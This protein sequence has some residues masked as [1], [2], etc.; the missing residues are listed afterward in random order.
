MLEIKSLVC[1]YDS[2][3]LLRDI[4][5]NL[6]DKEILGIIGPNGSG[7]T[8][9]LR[10]VRRLIKP[11]KGS[12]L[13]ERRDIWQIGVKELAKNIAVV[14]QD[15]PM[16]FMTVE[17]FVLLGRIPHFEQFQFLETKEDVEAAQRALVLTDTLRFKDRLLE[18]MSGGE[19]Q[20]VLI[21]RA[22][23]QEPKLLLLDEPTAHL[24]I[25]HQVSILDLIRRLRKEFGLT[26]IVVL[27]D[28][29]LASE[30]CDRLVLLNNG[31]LERMGL[32]KE[33]LTY[34][35]IEH[36]YK[37]I[38]VVEENPISKKP[39]VLLVSQEERKKRMRL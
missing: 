37:T 6:E 12:I 31:R 11:K 2:G 33:V 21:G 35:V 5:F 34:Q 3:F 22:L 39:Y 4:N 13:F 26:V 32:P 15:T 30:Y 20:L 7:K 14:S 18:E 8:T 24:D 10:A 23:A 29:N 38:V 9:L 36:V 19:R 25:T 1:G 16:G 27:H 28:L 17:E